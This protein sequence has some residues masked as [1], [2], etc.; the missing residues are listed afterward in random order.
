MALAGGDFDP[1]GD[2]AAA[3]WTPA[4]SPG[5]PT[6]LPATSIATI[7]DRGGDDGPCGDGD[8]APAFS[9]PSEAWTWDGT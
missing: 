7:G 2:M 8:G 1:T 3:A 5:D 9:L 6:P 4:L